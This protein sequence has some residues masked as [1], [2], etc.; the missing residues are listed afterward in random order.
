MHRET[1]RSFLKKTAAA[2]A[3][4]LVATGRAAGANERVVVGLIGCGG[5]GPGVAAAMGNVGFVCDPDGKRAAGA[6][7]ECITCA[8]RGIS[9]SI[10]GVLVQHE[11]PTVCAGSRVC[12][13]IT[14]NP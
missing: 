12:A 6:V 9:F 10:T 8:R 1:R 14:V 5:R 11:S 3:F 4:G 7:A 2:A 13:S